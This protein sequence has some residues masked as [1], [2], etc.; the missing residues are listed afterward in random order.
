MLPKS[1]PGW[2]L[3]RTDTNSPYGVWLEMSPAQERANKRLLKDGVLGDSADAVMVNGHL[4]VDT[5]QKQLAGSMVKVENGEVIPCLPSPKFDWVVEKLAELG[6][7]GER[8]EVKVNESGEIPR[9]VIA[10]Q[11]TKLLNL[12]AREL[13]Q[14]GIDAWLLT[15]EQSERKRM[16]AMADF[17][18]EH[19]TRQ[20]ALINT[21][22]AG[23]AITLDM[24]DDLVI[25]DETY[26][27]DDQ[28]Q[29]EDRVHRTGRAHNVNIWY[30]RMLGSIEEEIG[31]VTAARESVA[32]YLLDKSRGVDTAKRLYRM[33]QKAT[34]T[35]EK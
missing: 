22:A 15:G 24:A 1:Y 25:L 11:F 21:K 8:D 6:I 4:A 23:V 28:E 2:H 26:N 16:E 19:P 7:D 10:S 35:R 30:L 12:F 27:P 29:V 9:I 18:S 5:R 14:L 20:V 17:Q 33:K 34:D 32:R 13:H 31:W 3:D